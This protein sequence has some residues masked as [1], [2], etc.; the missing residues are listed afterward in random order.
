MTGTPSAG[1]PSSVATTIDSDDHGKPDRLARQKPLAEQQQQDRHKPDR[2]H[3]PVD[4][5]ELAG[6]LDQAI[7]EIVPAAGDA[8]QA[9]QLR[10]DDG[11]ARAGLEADQNAVADQAHQHAEPENPG[12]QAEQPPPQ[13]PPGWRSG[14]YRTASP[15]ASAPTVPAIISE[16]AEVG[17]TASWRDDA[18][19]RVADA[20]QHVAVDADLRR[21]AGKRR[22][23]Q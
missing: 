10:H 3:D 1:R 8:E 19:Q 9:R 4:A 11:Q 17:P 21:Q 14:A 12:D 2:Q 15:P 18:E 16:I 5:A 23:G 13:R 20:A 22:I 6:E 7:E